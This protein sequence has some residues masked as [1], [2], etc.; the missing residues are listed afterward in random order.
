VFLHPHWKE[1]EDEND[2]AI[3]RLATPLPEGS[4]L[5]HVSP[6]PI[7]RARD[8]KPGDNVVFLGSG[9]HSTGLQGEAGGTNDGKL[10]RATNILQKVTK[11]FLIT[12]F[13]N[14][15]G[16]GKPA[17]PGI[18]PLEGVGLS[19]DSGCP[20]FISGGGKAMVA[21]LNANSPDADS[22]VGKYGSGDWNI[23]V[24]SFLDF[25]DAPEQLARQRF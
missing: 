25:I 12:R 7:Y 20:V 16:N 14:P 4:R 17:E 15:G 19:G 10:R 5:L 9:R 11:Q 24:S 23:R 8:E 2:I 18:T 3:I 22:K 6:I 13:R 1:E 21:G